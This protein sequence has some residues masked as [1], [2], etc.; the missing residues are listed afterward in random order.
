MKFNRREMLKTSLTTGLVLGLNPWIF[1]AEKAKHVYKVGAWMNGLN[2]F[3]EA[4]KMGLEVLQVSMP[5]KKGGVDDIRDPEVCKKLLDRSQE[6][7][8]PIVSLALGDFNGNPLWLIDDAGERV[9][10]T[11][12]AMVRLKVDNVLVPF[13]GKAVLN[14]DDRF[15]E[16]IKRLKNLAKKAEDNGVFLAIESTLGADGHFR[17]I[18]GVN[19]PAI[20]VFYDPGNM[21]HRFKNTDEI[22]DDIRKLKGYIACVHAKDS[23]LL[24]KGKID[25]SK[26]LNAYREVGY[27]GAQILEG[28]IDKEIGYADSNRRNAEYLRTL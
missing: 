23:T 5:F 6:T 2:A 21:I 12:D 19:S 22:C 28:S 25:Y 13:F 9:S 1:G 4:K 15:A 7:G 18:N 17:I 3:N 11:I 26:I 8:I 14:A 16:T 27:F 20:K 10:E 24:G